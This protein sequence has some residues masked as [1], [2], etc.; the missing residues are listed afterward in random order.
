[1]VVI[2]KTDISPR[3]GNTRLDGKNIQITG[4]EIC[5]RM[6]VG[7]PAQG[8][9]GE[10]P[11]NTWHE[12]R[13]TKNWSKWYIVQITQHELCCSVLVVETSRSGG[14]VPSLVPDIGAGDKPERWRR[15]HWFLCCNILA[16]RP[17]ITKR[18]AL[19][20]VFTQ[21]GD[22]F[23]LTATRKLKTFNTCL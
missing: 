17:S 18:S 15:L 10:Y 2:L 4:H 11:A 1:M 21:K 9:V 8:E 23:L 19:T 12:G 13:S 6:S 20:K 16:D 7:R 5:C 22:E 14:R 3:M